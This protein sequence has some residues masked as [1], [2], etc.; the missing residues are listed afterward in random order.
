MV[1]DGTK[2]EL[3]TCN[4]A[5]YTRKN[6]ELIMLLLHPKT[7]PNIKENMLCRE[8]SALLS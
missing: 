5:F 3:V 1:K 4:I 6:I 8:F 2:L 7:K